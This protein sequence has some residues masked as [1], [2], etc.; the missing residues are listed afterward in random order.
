MRSL[1]LVALVL[2]VPGCT[3]NDP[4]GGPGDDDFITCP[5]WIKWPH[6]AYIISRGH[7][8]RSDQPATE[9][10]DFRGPYVDEQGVERR[11]T[12]LGEGARI[13]YNDHPLDFLRIDFKATTPLNQSDTTLIVVDAEVRLEFLASQ[14][15]Y[16]TG[17]VLRAYDLS[18]GPSSAQDEW[19]FRSDPVKGYEVFNITFQVD[20]AQS[21]EDPNPRGVF[22]HWSWMPNL[23]G[24]PDTPSVLDRGYVPEL[25]YRTCSD[26]G[27]KV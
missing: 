11:G 20:L 9:A 3:Q 14:D 19:V 10:W 2:L 13:E 5:S 24:N 27:T 26:D 18:K 21:D 22:L 15:G 7:P 16:P 1:A 8:L 23:D 12:A 17:E 6:D 25:W 4:G